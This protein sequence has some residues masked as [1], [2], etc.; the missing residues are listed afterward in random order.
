MVCIYLFQDHEPLD[1]TRC[2]Y[3]VKMD[4]N[5]VCFNG[6]HSTEKY[7]VFVCRD[8]NGAFIIMYI[9]MYIGSI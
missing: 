6:K 9:Y 8:Y 5:V 7:I 2:L 4:S 1:I 3:S